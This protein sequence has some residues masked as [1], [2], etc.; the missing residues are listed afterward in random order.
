MIPALRLNGITIRF[1]GLTAAHD[2]SLDIPEGKIV[3]VIGPNG[4]GKT[5]VFNS[6]TG[7]YPPDE[8][9][10][11][12]QGID[13]R[14]HLTPKTLGKSI[15]LG[16]LSAVAAVIIVN[17]QTLWDAV[18]I[19]KFIYGDAFPWSGVPRS[20]WDSLRSL[21]SL[22]T[23]L[24]FMLAG[25]ITTIGS[26]LTWHRSRHTPLSASRRGI[27]RTFQNI[28][29]FSGM[30]VLENV[31]VGMHRRFNSGW[32]ATLLNLP[33]VRR[34]ELAARERAHEILDF[35][36]LASEAHYPASALPYGSQRR[37]EIARALAAEPSLV[38][39][40]EPA[41]GMNPS[42][43]LDLINLIAKIRDQGRTIMLIEHHM[44]L[45]MEISDEVA[46]LH[47]GEKIAHGRP[48]VVRANEEVIRA[49]LGVE[50]THEL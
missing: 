31:L 35:V 26:L 41:A 5:T 34:E 24:P 10:I 28:R 40:D 7:V 32:I 29:I 47:Y 17:C 36:G 15:S 6:I 13:V 42:E 18:I 2:V 1:G 48:E 39:L 38:L 12:L 50:D 46:V 8:G 22:D 4:A 9:S 25:F 16:I 44:K 49:Y 43:M 30:T 37:L 23:W 20:L 27:S 19:Q 14:D 21:S 45:V 3:S 11:H 33:R